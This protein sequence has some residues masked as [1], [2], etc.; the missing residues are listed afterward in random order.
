MKINTITICGG[1][2]AAH[3]MIPIIR[4]HFSGKLNLF[5][6]FGDEANHF[7]KLIDKKGFL[8]ATIGEKKLYGRPDKVSKFA[9][10]VC[11]EA[12]LIL[13]PLPA[14]AHEQT[15]LQIV[16][17]LKE[18]AIIGA[19]PARS[20]FEYAAL[21][22]LKDNQKEEVKIFGLQTLP[23][24][25]RIKEYAASVNILGK[26]KSVGMAAFP[27][28]IT[29]KLASFLSRVLDLKIEPLPN[30]LT[31]TLANVGQIIHPGIMCGLFKGNEQATY[32]EETIP[33]FYQGVT[34]EIAKTLKAMSDE[35][36]ILTEKIKALDKNVNLD[37]VLGLKDW[38]IYSY[39][40]SIEDKSTIQTCFNTNSA[41]QGLR[42][43]VKKENDY[44]LPD[45]NSRYLTEDVPFGL[46][47]IKFI[48]KLAEVETPVIDE[49]ILTISQWM[50]KEYI[51][52]G[53]LEGKDIKDA[54]IPQNYG[55][56]NLEEIIVY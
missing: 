3:A 50:G 1:G 51:K 21:K 15:L 20:G 36:L 38:L 14:F 48:A 16:P 40:G 26:K 47:V 6:P 22:I 12:D 8:S 17:F 41:Y 30:M 45:F 11:K 31:L 35:I 28:K 56:K 7:Q 9:K 53:F 18:E 46:I 54:R 44:F 13:I 29:P 52:G 24:A 34:K 4:N 32:Q 37:H 39:E 42:A 2:N 55:I 43:P 19:I 10:E 33:L 27:H 25:C 5:L 23:W 49:I